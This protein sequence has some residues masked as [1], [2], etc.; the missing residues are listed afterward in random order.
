MLEACVWVLEAYL[1]RGVRMGA[2]CRCVEGMRRGARCIPRGAGG[3]CR[4]PGGMSRVLE[5]CVGGLEVCV[6]V[7][8]YV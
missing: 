3:V 4:G 2:W 5:A 6:G 7:W 8:K 1:A